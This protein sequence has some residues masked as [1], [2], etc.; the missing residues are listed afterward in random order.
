MFV[1]FGNRDVNLSSPFL[2]NDWIISAVGLKRQF[3]K[4]GPQYE[5]A[6]IV[7]PLKKVKLSK[8]T[9]TFWDVWSII[10]QFF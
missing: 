7:R 3:R 5:C 2:T 10:C 9:L 8:A 1:H 6:V 4:S